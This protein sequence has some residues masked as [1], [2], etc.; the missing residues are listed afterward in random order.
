[1]GLFIVKRIVKW[2]RDLFYGPGNI[3]LDLGR[4]L[5]TLVA[6]ALIGGQLWNMYLG[7]EID[8]GPG[9]LG[10]GLA[11]ILTAAAALI[12]AKDIARRKSLSE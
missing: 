7:K 8:L 3:Y 11:A 5:S 12:A 10:G 6:L 1:M 4:I 9:G 2:L